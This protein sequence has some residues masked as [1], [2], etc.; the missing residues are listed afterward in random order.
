MKTYTNNIKGKDYLYA[1][2][3]IFIAKGKSI[4]KNKSLGPIDAISEIEI[5]KQQFLSFLIEEEKKLRT[6]Y[7]EKRIKNKDFSKYISIGKLENVRTELYRA[8]ENMG[9][10]ANSAM[11][12]A[13]LVDFIYN[14]NKIEGSKI[15]RENIEKQVKKGRIINDEIGN[16]QKAVYYVNNK[17]KFSI[18]QI[19]K[20]H[21]V[22]LEHEPKKLGF[23]KEKVIVTNS[24]VTNWKNIEKEL[25]TLIK[26]FKNSQNTWYPPEL[27]FEFYFRFERIHP[28]IDGN[29]RTGRLILNKILKE[30]KYHP[31]II[32]NKRRQAHLSAFE[33]YTQGR[34]AKFF[35]FMSEQFI[36]THQIYIEKIQKAFDLEK[37]LNYFLKPSKYNIS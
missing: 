30:Q 5:K 36:K 2:D 17:F 22:L 19:K 28:F 16:T 32:W 20:L 11:E 1:Y 24:N 33:S 18:N 23:R 34:G 37:Q 27:A 9:A 14:S 4:Q 7:W 26:W 15:P 13:F 21:A 29:G 31:M 8:K 3:K 10:M 6:N 25:Q 12:T 35:K